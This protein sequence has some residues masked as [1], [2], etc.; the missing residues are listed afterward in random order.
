MKQKLLF[1]LFL[2]VIS[3]FA[4]SG[5]SCRNTPTATTKLKLWVVNYQATNFKNTIDSFSSQNSAQI[6]VTEKTAATFETDLL[7]A[8]ASHQGPDVVMTDSDFITQ[9]KDIFAPC[10]NN[11]SGKTTDCDSKVVKDK[12]VDTVNS[13]VFDNKIYGYPFKVETPMV[14]YNSAMFSKAENITKMYQV[15]YFWNEFVTLSRALT[16]KDSSGNIT[17][18]GLAIGTSSNVPNASDI[19]YSIMLQNST[20][21][22][23]NTPPPLAL[24]Q[25]PIISETGGTIYPGIKAL[26]FYT[27][28][29][30]PS[31]QNY[32]FN[33]SF[34]TAWKAFAANKVAMIIDYPERLDDIRKLNQNIR[35][36]TS[37]F[38]Q[39]ENTP[40]PVVYGK[41]AAFGITND[42]SNHALA[43]DLARNLV[44]NFNT[45][46]VK[47]G[48]SSQDWHLANGTSSVW[49]AEA[50]FAQTVYKD[51]Y[52]KEFDQ[53]I[54]TMIDSV[55]KK[56]VIAP[57]AIDQA[58]NDINQLIQA[59]KN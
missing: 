25:A 23:S 37:L 36:G 24:F 10:V 2:G 13:L 52:Y 59:T 4:V 31:S 26:E 16:Q 11:V 18:S 35:I 29:S 9:H 55:A 15:P 56:Q 54:N 8:L 32:S 44:Q 43:W 47:K 14:F 46:Y 30:N 38:P 48:T 45:L 21:I 53:T 7:N 41:V 57:T 42:S 27:S 40:N 17:V 5:L 58:A 1:I 49:Q 34:D 6:D 22:S 3:V 50:N 12:Y 51:K 33:S 20:K 39:I 19:L 28:F